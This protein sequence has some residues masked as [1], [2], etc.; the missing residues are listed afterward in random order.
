MLYESVVT[1]PP[2][3]PPSSYPQRV[4][5]AGHT[6][7]LGLQRQ[8]NLPSPP[9]LHINYGQPLVTHHSRALLHASVTGMLLIWK[10]ISSTMIGFKFES[11]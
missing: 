1:Y 2:A 6:P 5:T 9:S 7:T 3:T 8:P 4:T 10:L 11:A